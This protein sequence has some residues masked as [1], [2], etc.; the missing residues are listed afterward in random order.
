MKRS[1]LLQSRMVFT[2]IVFFGYSP[3]WLTWLLFVLLIS[4]KKKIKSRMGFLCTMLQGMVHT[5][6]KAKY[7]PTMVLTNQSN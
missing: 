6:T 3:N 1:M 4:K 5:H 7:K 2:K